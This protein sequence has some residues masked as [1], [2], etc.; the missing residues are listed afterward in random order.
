MRNEVFKP[1]DTV[2]QSG[3]YV[4]FHTEHRPEHEVTLREGEVFPPC[5][6]CNEAVR[7]EMARL[8]GGGKAAHGS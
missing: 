7:F 4:V 3:V 6:V 5:S 2:R 8:A 1:G